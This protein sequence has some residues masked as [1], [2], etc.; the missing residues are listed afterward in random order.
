MLLEPGTNEPYTCSDADLEADIYVAAIYLGKQSY[1][2]SLIA[3][4][5]EFCAVAGRPDVD[6]T[7]VNTRTIFDGV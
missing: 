6:S 5:I 7:I 4:G 2:E 3:D 1:V